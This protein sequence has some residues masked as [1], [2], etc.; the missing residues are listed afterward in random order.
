[1]WKDAEYLNHQIVEMGMKKLRKKHPSTLTSMENL[2]VTYAHQG[3]YEQAEEL[4]LNV[5][6]LSSDANALPSLPMAWLG[7]LG[8][9]KWLWAALSCPRLAKPIE[10][11][12]RRSSCMDRKK[13]RH[14]TEWNWGQLDPR[15]RLLHFRV[16]SVAS[17]FI[18]KIFK[19]RPKTGCNQLQPVFKLYIMYPYIKLC[20]M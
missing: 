14:R 5:L 15:L 3:K 19:N 2:A 4:M 13:N 17:C 9:W 18:L 11:S 20:S 16:L 7:H 6:D 1:M 12:V 10:N 8:Q